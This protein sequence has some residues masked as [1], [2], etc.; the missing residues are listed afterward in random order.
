VIALLSVAAGVLALSTAF[1]I[2]A[3]T[4]EG[5]RTALSFTPTS[6]RVMREGDEWFEP[7]TAALLCE[8]LRES[9]GDL[10]SGVALRSDTRSTPTVFIKEPR[11][12]VGW[13][14]AFA[15]VSADWFSLT[16]QRLIDGRFFTENEVADGSRVCVVGAAYSNPERFGPTK[17]RERPRLQVGDLVSDPGFFAG[18][19]TVVGILSQTGQGI[20]CPSGGWPQND[21]MVIFTPYTSIPDIRSRAV[22]GLPEHE[23]ARG[24]SLI[25]VYPEDVDREFVADRVREVLAPWNEPG[26]RVVIEFPD[27]MTVVTAHLQRGVGRYFVIAGAFVTALACLQVVNAAME[28]VFRRMTV[29]GIRRSLG[30][31]Q[32]RTA[33]GVF[34]WSLGVAMAGGVL[35]LGLGHWLVPVVS[36]ALGHE[37]SLT[38]PAAVRSFGYLGLF[39]VV[40][41]LYPAVVAGAL[42]PV[43]AIQQGRV[44]LRPRATL[45]PR[46][47]AACVAVSLGVGAALLLA[48]IGQSSQA[49]LD[50]YLRSCGEHTLVVEEADP[51][52]VQ[53]PVVSVDESLF[54]RLEGRL[55]GLC[56]LSYTS[57]VY[58]RVTAP[59]TDRSAGAYA[60]AVAGDL[61]STRDLRCA[62]GSP[63]V[64]GN[65]VVV[66][67]RIAAEL[68]GG[69]SEALGRTIRVADSDDLVIAGVLQERP[70]DRVDP[71]AERDVTVFMSPDQAAEIPSFTALGPESR[72]WVEPLGDPALA[73][74]ALEA[75]LSRLSQQRAAPVVHSVLEEVGDLETFRAVLAEGMV[76]MCVLGIVMGTYCVGQVLGSRALRRAR[77]FAIR[78]SL[79]ADRGSIMSL[80][81]AEGL[82]FC[83]FAGSAG[84]VAA[85]VVAHFVARSNGWP[86]VLGPFWAAW[87]LVLSAAVGLAASLVPA[88]AAA[89]TDPVLVMR[90]Q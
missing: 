80:V 71:D 72:I 6:L 83:V 23:P 41:G 16:E 84:I 59:E 68:F 46:S 90:A 33:M 77:E 3:A 20:P 81:A 65:Q 13:P 57:F 24:L 69:P 43:A 9:L 42:D 12:I 7:E 60:C 34:G 64:G 52:I 32:W 78:R 8:L 31:T 48:A 50:N 66:G 5:T 36:R 49:Y 70:R 55:S 27:P 75:E 56:R 29:M 58:T 47:V 67:A 39:S 28:M 25:V 62:A 18:E 88:M 86:L 2:E 61:W 85:A 35:G 89:R 38:L 37:A 22:P 51:Y 74:E 87:G 14:L 1:G 53:G 4:E 63:V 11:K 30:E 21:D 10:C 82:R 76:A 79:G 73:R 26:K 45:D 19:W 17:Y 44:G 40:G 54:G 15:G